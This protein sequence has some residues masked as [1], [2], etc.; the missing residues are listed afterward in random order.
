MG[1]YNCKNLHLLKESIQ[2]IVNQTYSNW[3]FIICNDGSTD[4]T[5]DELHKIA[6]I[7]K[8]I[9]IITYKENRG[10]AHALNECIKKANGKYIVRQ[11]D[12]D[13]SRLDRIEKLVEFKENNPDYAIVGSNARVFDNNGVWGEYVVPQEPKKK[14]FLWNSPFAHPTVLIEKDKLLD[15]NGY[16]EA[17][18]TRRC[19]DYDLFME[20][21][22]KGYRGYNIQ[23]KLYDY[24]I[25][26]N[27]EKKYRPMKYRIDEAIVRYKGYKKLG[28][29]IKGIP[30]ILKPVLIGLLPQGI[31]Y[32]IK[33]R[34]Y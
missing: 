13:L 29:V 19:E 15:V 17:K 27:K 31:L 26:N 9:R 20:M 33:K 30:Y 24:R 2:S 8:R 32:K 4:N 18:E 1:V 28:M 11:D 14:D 34:Q 10:L 3:E 5:L 23:E 7:D 6:N 16:R 22:S 12:D 21:Y 25:E